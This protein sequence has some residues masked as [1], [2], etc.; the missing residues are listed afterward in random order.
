MTINYPSLTEEQFIEKYLR[1]YNLMVPEEQ[2]LMDSEISL[3]IEFAL[4][5]EE[6]F[7][8]QRFGGLAKTKVVES[9]ANKGWHLTK[10]NINNKLYALIEKGFLKRDED[11]VIYLPKHIL[12]ALK[13]FK[14]SKKFNIQISFSNGSI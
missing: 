2:Q 14:D 10:L 9:A 3:L 1:F 13:E 8:Y 11:S 12:Q 5:P 6:K 4:L 7:S